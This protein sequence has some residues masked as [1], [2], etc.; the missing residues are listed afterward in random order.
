M[1]LLYQHSGTAGIVAMQHHH[2]TDCMSEGVQRK[3]TYED[4]IDLLDEEDSD[5]DDPQQ[6]R[7]SPQPAS[8]S[9]VRP[10]LDRWLLLS[11]CSY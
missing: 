11:G 10:F 9:R 5:G 8:A 6:M 3:K 4:V 1:R 7:S 2:N